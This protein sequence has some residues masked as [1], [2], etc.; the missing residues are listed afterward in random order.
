MFD[1][2]YSR[3]RSDR[4]P[5]SVLCHPLYFY[6]LVLRRSLHY[7]DLGG[8]FGF[9]HSFSFILNFYPLSFVWLLY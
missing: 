3:S 5:C 1:L 7:E 6:S 8:L 4:Q 9:V 2:V